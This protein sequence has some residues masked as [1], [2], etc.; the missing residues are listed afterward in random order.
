MGFEI[1]L[2]LKVILEDLGVGRKTW[3]GYTLHLVFDNLRVPFTSVGVRYDLNH[4]K[5]IGPD[6]GNGYAVRFTTMLF[7]APDGRRFETTGITPDVEVTQEPGAAEKL[8]REPDAAARVAADAP[9]RAA[10]RLVSA[11]T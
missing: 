8:R 10:L 11:G 1:G 7:A 2:N 4:S 6:N 5:W 9:L 3:W